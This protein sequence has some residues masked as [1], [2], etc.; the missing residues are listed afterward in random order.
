MHHSVDI[1]DGQNSSGKRA[2]LS[3][4]Y[5][6]NARQG[7]KAITWVPDK[8]ATLLCAHT[9]DP[10][11][12][13][14]EVPVRGHGV[15]YQAEVPGLAWLDGSHGDWLGI[16]IGLASTDETERKRHSL[17]KLAYI[18]VETDLDGNCSERLISGVGQLAV[19]VRDFGPR[20]T[21]GFTHL[22]AADGKLG[23][24]GVCSSHAGAV[25]GRVRVTTT[26]HHDQ[27]HETQDDD[28]RGN[29]P[30]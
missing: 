30:R 12:G 19:D 26:A 2:L 29:D 25:R 28:K 11:L 27:D 17:G 18:T 21:G 8:A 20:K 24:I 22:Q 3:S 5:E 15:E 9:D 6:K 4:R 1:F 10:D 23:G 13:K 7:D 16:H 14:L